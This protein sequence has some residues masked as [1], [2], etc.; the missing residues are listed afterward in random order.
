M[1]RTPCCYAA[2]AA[3]SPAGEVQLPLVGVGTEAVE[4]LLSARQRPGAAAGERE[5][6]QHDD[7]DEEEEEEEEEE[8]GED[9]GELMERQFVGQQVVHELTQAGL[10]QRELELRRSQELLR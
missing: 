6:Q 7:D 2:A 4:G 9:A 5:Q 8:A 1:V 10:A 3:A